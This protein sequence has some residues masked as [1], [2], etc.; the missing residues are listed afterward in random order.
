MPISKQYLADFQEKGIYHVYNRTNNKEQL[1]L[2]E[3]NCQYFLEKYRY[4]LGHLADT[5]CWCLLPNHFHF[6]VSIREDLEIASILK[7]IKTRAL[8]PTESRFLEGACTL[9][10]LIRLNFRRFFQSYAMSFNKYYKRNGN[11]FYRPFKR[12]QVENPY[13]LSQLVV[14]IH[15]NPVKH[16]TSNNYRTYPWSSYQEYI[17]NVKGL[18][19]KEPV[20]DIFGSI[21]SFEEEHNRWE[22]ELNQS[23][24]STLEG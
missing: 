3:E 6:L 10:E 7:G 2:Y 24:L 11:L 14:Y 18:V 5:L 23:K 22:K 13:H 21:T 15:T 4:Y 1:F 9:N 16:G 8:S 20:L 12:I 17:R 19:T